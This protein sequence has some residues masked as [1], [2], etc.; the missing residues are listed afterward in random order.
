[1]SQYHCYDF[2]RVYYS[3]SSD[4]D[5]YATSGMEPQFSSTLESTLHYCSTRETEDFGS[6]S[7]VIRSLQI[8]LG[9]KKKEEN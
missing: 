7:R 5:A 2:Y 3:Q 6:G 8:S 1:M 9:A 4:I